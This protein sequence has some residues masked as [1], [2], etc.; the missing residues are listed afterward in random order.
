[1]NTYEAK[2]NYRKKEAIEYKK[3]FQVL[4]GK[5]IKNRVIKLAHKIVFKVKEL[6][7]IFMFLARAASKRIY[8]LCI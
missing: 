7:G 8:Y 2:E 6:Y 1:M 3:D 5:Y 4:K